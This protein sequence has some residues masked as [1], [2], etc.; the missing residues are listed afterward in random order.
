MEFDVVIVGAGLVGASLARSLAGSGL[1]IALVEPSVP[2]PP[3]ERWDTRIYALS[4]ASKSFLESFDAWTELDASRVTPVYSMHVCGD[5]GRSRLEFS[6]YEAGLDALAWMVESSRLQ[7]AMWMQL[8]RQQNVSF[9]CPARPVEMSIREDCVVLNM[10]GEQT[11]SG[12]LLVGADGADSWVR[13]SADMPAHGRSYGQQGVVANFAC[14]RPHRNVAYQWFRTDGV[15]AYLPLP[16]KL[17]SMVWSAPDALASELLSLPAADLCSRVTQA[18]QHAL[19]ELS[20]VTASAAFPLALVSVNSMVR[21]RVALIGDAAHV[22]HPLAGQGVNLGFGDARDLA[23][24]LSQRTPGSDVGE[25]SLLRR[26]ERSR[27]EDI[28][29]MRLV[30]DGLARLF[31]SSFPGIAWVRN[32]GLNLAN[33]LPVIRT[34]LV[35]RAAG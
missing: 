32:F 15:L 19:G 11:V 18:G 10:E 5:N 1:A 24:V 30:T 35:R 2:T 28:L 9:F 7:H 16:G 20:P 14:E 12:K 21:P 34:W 26:F 31:G 25:L 3:E 4:P 22:I 27:A 33:S 17:I 8:Q 6:A 23:L 29:A 13:R